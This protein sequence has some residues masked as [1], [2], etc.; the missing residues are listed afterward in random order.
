M[1]R[2]GSTQDESHIQNSPIPVRYTRH[3]I[4]SK[5]KE[6]LV[7]NYSR[8]T[9]NWNK[10]KVKTVNNKQISIFTYHLFLTDKSFYF[11]FHCTDLPE[12]RQCNKLQVYLTTNIMIQITHVLEAIYIPQAL[13]TRTTYFILWA[14]TGTCISHN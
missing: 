8:N 9:V 4:T 11:Y 1:N 12:A 7:R 5:K 14:H 13:D 10:T 6:K 3:H 2:T